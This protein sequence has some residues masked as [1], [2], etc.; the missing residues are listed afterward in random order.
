MPAFKCLGL[1]GALTEHLGL[2]VGMRLM[3]SGIMLKAT[4]AFRD[5]NA[6]NPIPIG[7]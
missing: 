7:S 1:Q 3:D 6:G 5:A 4:S 2:S